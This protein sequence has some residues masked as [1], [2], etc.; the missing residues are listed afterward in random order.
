M[1]KSIPE[2]ENLLKLSKAPV[3]FAVVINHKY[4]LSK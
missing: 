1:K 4:L 3:V 2:L